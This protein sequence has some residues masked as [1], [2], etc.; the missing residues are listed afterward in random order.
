MTAPLCLLP[1]WMPE[2]IE[3]SGPD[4]FYIFAGLILGIILALLVIGLL[5]HRGVV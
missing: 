5:K 1:D 4:R 3:L 2:S